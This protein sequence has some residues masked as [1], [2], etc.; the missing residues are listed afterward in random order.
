MNIYHN[1]KDVIITHSNKT[2]Y[3]IPAAV[4]EDGRVLPGATRA[5][6]TTG[7]SL[8]CERVRGASSELPE[9]GNDSAN[10]MQDS[11]MLAD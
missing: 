2:V 11:P 10:Q 1:Y 9:C 8:G 7:P 5:R 6:A 4:E 3:H